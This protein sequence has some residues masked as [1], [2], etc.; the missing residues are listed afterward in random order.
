MEQERP[1]GL[2]TLIMIGGAEDKIG[3]KVILS[4]LAQI[5]GDRKLVVSTIASEEPELQWRTYSRVFGELG[6]SNVSHLPAETRDELSDPA[7]VSMIEEAGAVFFTGGD[8][9][10]ITTKLGGTLTYNA[11]RTLYKKRS[12]VIAGTSAGAA[13]MGQV[14]LMATGVGGPEK[15]SIRQAFMMARGL[16]L[17]RDMVIDQH[18][19][20]RARIERLLGAIA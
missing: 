17:I 8:Q 15:H 13:A 9:L 18:F 5:V 19:A 16:S 4:T 1:D 11:V 10:K 20:Q 14:M 3:T 12:G 7:A 2:G 6:V